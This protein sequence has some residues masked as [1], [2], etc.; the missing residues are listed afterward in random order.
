MTDEEVKAAFE[1]RVAEV[2]AK[3]SRD[4]RD[5]GGG[6]LVVYLMDCHHLTKLMNQT[7]HRECDVGFR[8]RGMSFEHVLRRGDVGA[9]AMAIVA[10]L[11]ARLPVRE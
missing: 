6:D 4:V 1:H 7:G 3:W 11:N 9:R 2:R 10:E 8:L 5:V